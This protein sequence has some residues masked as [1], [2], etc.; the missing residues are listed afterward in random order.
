M[1]Y[2][3][4]IES[5][6]LRGWSGGLNREADPFLLEPE[7]VPDA[8]NVDF[9]LRGEASKRK[10]YSEQTGDVSTAGIGEF[11]YHWQK[12]G[13]SEYL[14]Y[15]DAAGKLWYESASTLTAVLAGSSFGAPADEREFNV[16]FA[17]MNDIVYVTSVRD[18]TTPHSFDGTTWVAM[19]A[20]A[21]DGTA[22]QFPHARALVNAHE[23]MF[24]F[25]VTRSDAT[26]FRSRMYYSNPLLPE[27][28]EALDY[29][30]FAPDDGQEIT[31]AVLFGE[32]VI[33]FKNHSMF[34]L[35][36]TDESNFTVYPIDTAVGTECPGTVVT[37]GPELFFFDHLSGVWSFD[38]TQ[39]DKVDDKI[40]EYLLDGINEAYAYK[41][42][43]FAYRG[44]YYLSV[45]WDTDTVPS[46]TFVYDGRIE[47]WTEYDFAWRDGALQDALMYTVGTAD[48][49]GVYE[50]WQVDNDDTG[51]I[52][53][54]FA[55]SWLA[56][57]EPSFKYRLRRLELAFSA[58]GDFEVTAEMRRDFTLDAFATQLINTT[59]GGALYGTAEYGTDKY[60]SGVSQV[61]S[62]T[63]G[64]GTDESVRWRVCQFEF[65]ES[66]TKP[67]Q[68]NRMVMQVSRIGRLRGEP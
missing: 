27:T 28:W 68:I 53:G 51:N 9:G 39:Y 32:Q 48:K 47:A 49:I 61:L 30:D 22:N 60:G 4:E 41:S 38:G 14:I 5:M 40:N 56:P 18:G 3:T 6:E 20:A 35:S 24:A 66:T 54:R 31:Q 7:E 63:T 34:A 16:T 44:K 46:R 65:S 59:P 29:I 33:V 17:S 12:L 2:T 58:E 67:F 25:N 43:G 42:R 55:T 11:L 23:R 50:M 36:G 19:T 15:I 37:S 8:V 52:D 62:R 26:D 45:P 57:A 1:P 21:L 64:W 13:G 10:G